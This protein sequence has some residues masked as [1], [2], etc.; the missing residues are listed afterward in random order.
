MPVVPFA[1]AA[2]AG[3][4]QVLVPELPDGYRAGRVAVRVRTVA[5][6]PEH[7]G[8]T[9]KVGHALLS[10]LRLVLFGRLVSA[11]D[12]LAIPG[13]AWAAALG[14]PD[15]ADEMVRLTTDDE[16]VV[17]RG[18]RSFSDHGSFAVCRAMVALTPW[19]ELVRVRLRGPPR[20][21]SAGTSSAAAPG[22]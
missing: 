17:A 10:I 5:L 19:T 3:E 1:A 6:P 12:E 15:G 11:A 2:T 8:F 14:A 13:T 22:S 20:S 16:F 4:W 18:D 21:R 7:R 9:G